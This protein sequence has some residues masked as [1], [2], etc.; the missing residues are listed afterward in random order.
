M[1]NINEGL[2]QRI[3]MEKLVG[4]VHSTWNCE[5]FRE[6]TNREQNQNYN[7]KFKKYKHTAIYKVLYFVTFY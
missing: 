2:L 6:L 1:Q 4:N 5:N 3:L 7:R